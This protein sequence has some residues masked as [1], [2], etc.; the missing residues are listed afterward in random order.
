MT[1]RPAL[2]LLVF[3]L[4]ALTAAADA[5]VLHDPWLARFQV[6]Q[7]RR[8][9]DVPFD[10]GWPAGL[11]D[12]LILDP[13]WKDGAAVVLAADTT[14][15]RLGSLTWGDS[16][17]AGA[18]SQYAGMRRQW[19]LLQDLDD[20]TRPLAAEV[21]PG[22]G[23]WTA[24]LRQLHA[25]RLWEAGAWD[26]AAA[27][28][29]RLVSDGHGLGLDEDAVFAWALRADLLANRAGLADRPDRLWRSLERLGLYD[30]RSG[31]AIWLAVRRSREQTPLPAG[32]ADRD[33]GVMLA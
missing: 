13:G 17:V 12:P 28:A 15:G 1:R 3:L 27:A 18:A 32:Q 22:A 4:L 23:P 5:A 25:S 14:G 10:H 33:T 21:D 26:D 9:A 11:L 2:P 19:R 24:Q 6:G 31:W 8:P 29:A 20:R 7:W 30:T 16:A